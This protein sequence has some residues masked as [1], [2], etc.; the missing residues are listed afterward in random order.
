MGCDPVQKKEKKSYGGVQE[1]MEKKPCSKSG[2]LQR[3]P[4][5][6]IQLPSSISPLS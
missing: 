1:P 6:L 5:E 3:L 2:T 4:P